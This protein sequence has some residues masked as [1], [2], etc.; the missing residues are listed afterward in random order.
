LQASVWAPHLLLTLTFGAQVCLICL[1]ALEP[2]DFESGEAIV[3]ECQCRGE[4]A[5]RHRTCAE[6]WARVK[7][8]AAGSARLGPGLCVQSVAVADEG[9]GRLPPNTGEHVA[10][11][12]APLR[13]R[14]Q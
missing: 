6:K 13:G 4:L 1:D 11:R 9:S 5:L 8:R 7:A 2:A 14:T 10:Q 12:P 3:L